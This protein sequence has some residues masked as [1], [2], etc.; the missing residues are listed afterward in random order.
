MNNLEVWMRGPIAGLAPLLQPV[1]H[2]ILQA[3]EEVN[4]MMIDFPEELLW[5]SPSDCA[6][7]AFHLQHLSGVLDRLFTYA[8]DQMLSE[9]QLDL[10]QLESVKNQYNINVKSLLTRFNN[11]VNK[12]LTQ[13]KNT[14]EKTLLETRGIGRKRIPTNVLGLLF[15]AAEHTQRH[16]GQLYVTVKMLK[17]AQNG[18][19][20][21]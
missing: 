17:N 6:S 2:A 19:T 9:E 10:L 16:T 21:F 13:L 20:Q 12:A 4:L 3:R 8:N 15:H 18:T 11:Q 14:D 5:E 7:V 1:A